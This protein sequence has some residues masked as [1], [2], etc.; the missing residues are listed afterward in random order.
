[1]TAFRVEFEDSPAIR[2]EAEDLEVFVHAYIFKTANKIVAAVPAYG[3]R[4]VTEVEGPIN[5]V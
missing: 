2:V 3:V 1:M 5:V 4:Y